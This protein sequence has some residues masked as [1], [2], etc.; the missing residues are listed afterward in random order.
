MSANEP[1]HPSG[2]VGLAVSVDETRDMI[3]LV[4]RHLRVPPADRAVELV[5]RWRDRIVESD[6]LEEPMDGIAD[7]VC[8]QPR[9]PVRARLGPLARR[10]PENALGEVA[11]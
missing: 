9:R 10:E 8:G 5:A 7:L 2:E 3:E 4:G 1:G 11:V 6:V